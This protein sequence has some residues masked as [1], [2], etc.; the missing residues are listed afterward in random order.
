MSLRQREEVQKMLRSFMIASWCSAG[1]GIG[2]SIAVAALLAGF[3]N[4]AVWP[5]KLGRYQLK[6]EKSVGVTSDKALWDEYGLVSVTEGD[7]GPF[8]ATAY[9]FRDATGA[10]AA[11]KWAQTFLPGATVA[12]STVIACQ[13]RCP[14][15][16]DLSQVLLAGKRQPAQPLVWAYLP[17]D[18]LVVRSARYALG[19]VGLAQFAPEIPVAMAAFQF[20]TEAVVGKYHSAKGDETLVLLAFPLSQIARKQEADL[21]KLPAAIV[22][23]SGP[24]V[25]VVLHSPEPSAAADLIRQINYQAQISWDEKQAPPITAQ[26]LASMILT[27]L[28]LAGVLI[29]F[30]IFA[31]VAFAGLRL[32]RAKLGPESAAEPMILLHLMD[33]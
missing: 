4:A 19:P 22:K 33:R 25:A 20:N 30:C 12:G 32:L 28:A 3:A 1:R 26:S 13:G 9:R 7:Y 5:A 17:L 6:A 24:L 14:Q 31:G 10:F 15:D 2:R 29:L 8:R 18:G 21:R 23:R 16:K 27:M 11:Q